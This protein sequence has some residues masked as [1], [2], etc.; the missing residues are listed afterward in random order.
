MDEDRILLVLG[1]FVVA[2]LLCYLLS[3]LSL[4]W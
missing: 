3:E 2:L 1:W 4:L